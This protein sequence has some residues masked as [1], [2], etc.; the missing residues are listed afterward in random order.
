MVGRVAPRAPRGAPMALLF[1]FACRPARSDAP[2]LQLDSQTGGARVTC[3]DMSKPAQTLNDE[4]ALRLIVEGT[5]SETGT[6]FFRALVRNLATVMNTT[7]GWVTEYL[8]ET[9]RLRAH[10]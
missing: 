1:Q 9:N 3:A 4:A 6:E 5:V 7:G 8:R 10:A 2:Y